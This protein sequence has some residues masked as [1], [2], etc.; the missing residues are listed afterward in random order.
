MTSNLSRLEKLAREGFASPE[1]MQRLIT[2]VRRYREQDEHTDDTGTGEPS[3]D[4]YLTRLDARIR[5][6]Y[7]QKWNDEASRNA[8]L[9]GLVQ[10]RN[11]Y[12]HP[13]DP[14]HSHR[15]GLWEALTGPLPGDSPDPP[16]AA[17]GRTDTHGWHM[18]FPGH[19]DYC[20]GLGEAKGT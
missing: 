13:D 1:A 20:G 2:E 18:H 14:L 3:R 8:Q 12:V 10:A 4:A 16:A 5:E 9:G 11:A 6:L 7:G 17:C 19:G 15:D